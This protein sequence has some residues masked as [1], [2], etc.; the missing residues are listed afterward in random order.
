MIDRIGELRSQAESAIA[1]APSRGRGS[2]GAA[3]TLPRAPRRAA[4]DPARRP[5]RSTS[6]ERG[7][8]GQG[9]ANQAPAARSRRCS[10]E[11]ASQTSRGRARGCSSK[12]D[13]RRRDAAR[14]PAAADRPPA[15]AQLHLAASSKT[16]SSGSASPSWTKPRWRPFTTTSTRSTTRRRI[17]RERARTPSTWSEHGIRVLRTHTSPMQVRAMEAHPPPL[18]VVIPGR[19]F[20]PDS[21]ATHTPGVSPDRG[22]RDRRGHHAR[23]PQGHALDVRASSV[24]RGVARCGCARIISRSPSRASRWTCR[25]FTAAARASWR[26]GS[27]CYLCKGEGWLEVLG[28]GEVDPTLYDYIPTTAAQRAR[29]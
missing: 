14:L 25:A 5:P 24:R 29:L 16:S 20:R 10:C 8:G 19:V 4:P 12:R 15:R 28:A 21:D 6:A 17:P 26:D 3:R 2:G 7:R 13:A 27:R 18:Y 9:A 23:R 22:A 1:A 11:R